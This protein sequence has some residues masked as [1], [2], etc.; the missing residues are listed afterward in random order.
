MMEMF[1]RKRRKHSLKFREHWEQFLRP[2]IFFPFCT[3]CTHLLR[4]IGLAEL[5]FIMHKEDIK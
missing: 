4:V 3:K 2:A 5:E 1:A